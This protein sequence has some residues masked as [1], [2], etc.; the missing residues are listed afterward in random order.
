MP[1]TRQQLQAGFRVGD[2]LIEPRQ[3]RIVRRDAEVRL[4]PRVMDVLV[5]LAA[6]AGEVVSRDTLNEEVW[7]HIVV[8]D[9]AVTNCISELRHHLTDGA[10]LIETIPKRGYRL[11]APV[12]LAQVASLEDRSRS[13]ASP[14]M[15]RGRPLFVTGLLLLGAVVVGVAWWWGTRASAPALTSVAVL[16]SENAAGDETLDYLALALP[17]EF[18]TLLTQS[19]GLA[20]RPLG[21][22]DGDEPIAA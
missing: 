22:V 21:Y 2:C 5:C 14:S 3:N 16:R 18:A 10:S 15:A 1:F 13:P 19:R 17:D 7:G 9:Q 11:A 20:V 4:E 12:Q 6:R 8:T